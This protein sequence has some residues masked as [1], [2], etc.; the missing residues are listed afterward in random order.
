MEGTH[1]NKKENRETGS[2]TDEHDGTNGRVGW[3]HIKPTLGVRW[4]INPEVRL[5]GVYMLIITRERKTTNSHTS[6]P[7]NGR[8]GGLTHSPN[9]E[10]ELHF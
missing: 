9:I 4:Q 10:L 5:A 2:H 3:T 6:P 1:S 7:T 8:L